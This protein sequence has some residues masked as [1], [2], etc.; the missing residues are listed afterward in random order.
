MTKIQIGEA[1]KEKMQLRKVNN[2]LVCQGAGLHSNTLK[3]IIEGETAYT[4]D[5]LV[6]TYY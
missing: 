2:Y 6:K 4:L 1:I 5:A 3:A